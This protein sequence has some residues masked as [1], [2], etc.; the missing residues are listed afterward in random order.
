MRDIF[1]NLEDG[2]LKDLVEEIVPFSKE[3]SHNLK[4]VL[5]DD[6]MKSVGLYSEVPLM[7]RYKKKEKFDRRSEEEI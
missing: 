6:D 7:E 2:E 1:A 4:T 5:D 3:H